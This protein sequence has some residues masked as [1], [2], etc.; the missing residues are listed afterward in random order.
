MASIGGEAGGERRVE[1]EH[2]RHGEPIVGVEGEQQEE[3]EY[4][5]QV[6][7]EEGER[8]EDVEVEVDAH[9]VLD[10]QVKDEAHGG[11]GQRHGEEERQV[12]DHQL[13]EAQIVA[14][15]SERGRVVLDH[16]LMMLMRATRCRCRRGA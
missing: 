4:E 3:L 9:L 7:G 13:V 5:M 16:R 2:A 6:E 1:G 10:E 15:A 12:D 8:V 11:V 14:L